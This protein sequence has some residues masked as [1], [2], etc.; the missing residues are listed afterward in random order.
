[1][2]AREGERVEAGG[3]VPAN[4]LDGFAVQ[5]ATFQTSGRA[6]QAVREFQDAGYLAYS[7]ERVRSDGVHVHGVF[8]GPYSERAVAERDRE[9]VGQVP[10][11]GT[12]LIVPIAPAESAQKTE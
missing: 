1:M 2:P 11:Y 6:A 4:P 3:L 7:A 5:M 9:R 8:L 12:G 10:G